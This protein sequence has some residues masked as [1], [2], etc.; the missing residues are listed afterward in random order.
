MGIMKPFQ[1]SVQLRTRS[2]Y[3]NIGLGLPHGLDVRMLHFHSSLVFISS[4]VQPC[5]SFTYIRKINK[6]DIVKCLF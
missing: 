6:T 2:I 3:L 4:K 5:V 1:L